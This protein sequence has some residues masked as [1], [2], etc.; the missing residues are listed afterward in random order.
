MI[1]GF[2]PIYKRELRAFLQSSSTYVVLGLLFLVV[3]AIFHLM[4]TQFVND[5]AMAA[6]GGPFN[7]PDEAPNVTVTLIGGTFQVVTAMIMFIVPV[8]T[9]RLIASEKSSGTFELLVTCPISDWNILI[10]KF[11]ALVTVGFGLLVLCS[12]YPATVYLV[13]ESQGAAPEPAVVAACFAGLVLIF[14]TYSAFGLMASAM[15][16]S[17]VTA[18]IVTLVGLLLWNSIAEFNM[19]NEQIQAI[20]N[21]ISAAKHTENFISGFI[22][23]RDLAFYAFATFICLFI[24]ART[25]EA[26]R[27]RV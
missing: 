20:A 9:M 10:G 19:P 7:T 26:R 6:A 22:T 13:G 15:T 25:L 5:S 2:W 27:W 11:L 18:A 16:D 23:L 24:A 3:G 4:L 14:A 1:F 8:L 12:V 21:E 17:Q